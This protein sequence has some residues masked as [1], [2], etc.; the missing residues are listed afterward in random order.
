LLTQTI[1]EAAKVLDIMVHDHLIV[2]GNRFFSF[3]EEGMMG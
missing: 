2:G 3:R 1:R